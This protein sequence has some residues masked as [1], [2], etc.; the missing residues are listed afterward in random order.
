MKSKTFICNTLSCDVGTDSGLPVAQML[1][2]LFPVYG[3]KF[4]VGVTGTLE[5]AV[6]RCEPGIYVPGHSCALALAGDQVALSF[7]V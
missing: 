3:Y 6:P 5:L 4:L 1:Y 7:R 2:L